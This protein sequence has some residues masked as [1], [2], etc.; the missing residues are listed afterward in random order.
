MILYQTRYVDGL[1][2]AIGEKS[3]NAADLFL[4]WVKHKSENIMTYRDKQFKSIFTSHLAPKGDVVWANAE[5][6]AILE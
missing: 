3:L 6:G 1:A 4:S 2:A 5:V